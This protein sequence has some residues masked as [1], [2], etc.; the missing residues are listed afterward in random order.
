MTLELE[1]DGK[2]S[3]RLNYVQQ[4]L[5]MTR[6][7]SGQ[8][9]CGQGHFAF[10]FSPGSAPSFVEAERFAGRIITLDDHQLQFK[11]PTGIESWSRAR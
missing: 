8:W 9:Q 7:V 3:L 11:S 2:G 5:R 10:T 6:D 4:G 1:A